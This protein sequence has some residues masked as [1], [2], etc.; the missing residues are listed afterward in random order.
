[1]KGKG[2]GGDPSF[3]HD[4]DVFHYLLEHHKLI[5]RSVKNLPNGVESLTESD[6]ADVARKLQD[7]VPAMYKRMKESR[8][9]R[10][11]D[12]LFVELFKHGDKVKMTVEKTAKGVK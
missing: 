9:V 11:W 8:P 10:M 4:R 2:M 1:G 6:N 3:V 5:R 7:H 12:P